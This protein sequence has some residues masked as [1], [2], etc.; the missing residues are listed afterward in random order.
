MSIQSLSAEM[1]SDLEKRVLSLSS[2]LGQAR[3]NIHKVIFGQEKVVGLCLTAILSGGHFLLIGLPGLGK[4]KLVE[5]LGTVMGLDNKRVQCTPDLMPADIL[6]SEILDGDTSSR[7]FRFI[8]GPVFCQLLMADEINRASPR[9]QSALLQAMQEYQVSVGGTTYDLPRPFHV[10]ATQNPLEQEGTY[11]LPEAQLDRFMLQID[12]GYPAAGDERKMM[13]A[14][15]GTRE[16]KAAAL[17]SADEV[18]AAQQ[19]VRQL[20]IG[21]KVV[22]GIL[23]L[24]QAGRPEQS[25][26]ASVKKHVSWGPGPRASQSL[27]LAA[28]AKALLDGRYAPSMDDVLELAPSILKHRMALHFSARAEGL[29]L[30]NIIQDICGTAA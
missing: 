12:I 2:R 14:T 8:K 28:R 30:D 16:E 22:D 29:T 6:G 20:P 21:Q 24:V 5:T 15:T 18:L 26:L 23:A 4:T 11:P 19:V 27:M 10:M 7:G 9:T 1:T 25:S 3:Q 13:L 17:F